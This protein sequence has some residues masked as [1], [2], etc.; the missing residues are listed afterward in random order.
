MKH[1]DTADLA[2]FAGGDLSLLAKL[3]VG[4]HLRSCA[5]CRLELEG[6]RAAAAH[7][8]ADGERL[9]AGLD[10]ER[11]A[12]E[13]TA[14]IHVG[15]EA[16]ECVAEHGSRPAWGLWRAAAVMA[17]MSVMLLAAWILNPPARRGEKTL[18]ASHTAEIRNTE[19]GLELNE[20]GNALV[21]LHGRDVQAQRPIIVSAP[22]ALRARFVD[23]DTGQI[24][25]THVYAE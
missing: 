17:A 24:T 1:P 21:L 6:F 22:G 7:L 19:N 10:W 23:S 12:A 11:V 15:L 20:N 16:G 9:P 13:M 18:R 3:R 8:R 2:L 25:I 4:A 5:E 14:N